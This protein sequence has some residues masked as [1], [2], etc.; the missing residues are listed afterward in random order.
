[1][2]PRNIEQREEDIFK[3]QTTTLWNYA[4]NLKPYQCSANCKAP[5]KYFIGEPWIDM[6]NQSI[7]VGQY[8]EINC[9]IW[10]G[11]VVGA[12]KRNSDELRWFF[13]PKG[14]TEELIFL[15]ERTTNPF[16]SEVCKI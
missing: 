9:K 15:K 7:K 16:S 4:Q 10:D 1:M 3:N 2:G 8:L 12:N 14:K 13:S 5:S 11:K 6:A